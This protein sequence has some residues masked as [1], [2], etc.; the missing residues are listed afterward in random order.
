MASLN[1]K[2]ARARKAQQAPTT[3]TPTGKTGKNIIT[4]K[5]AEKV[6]DLQ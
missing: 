5:L 3:S 6:E 1:R 4:E 2:L